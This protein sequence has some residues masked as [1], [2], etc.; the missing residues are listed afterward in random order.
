MSYK[1]PLLLTVALVL[2]SI[3]MVNAQTYADFTN[4]GPITI[5]NNSITYAPG[6]TALN[7]WDGE[8]AVDA[9]GVVS[10]SGTIRSFANRAPNSKT[11]NF[12]VLNISRATGIQST[13]ETN[14]YD[15]NNTSLII[16]STADFNATV[17]IGSGSGKKAILA[18]IKG[19]ISF[20]KAIY[21]NTYTNYSGT[22][23]TDQNNPITLYSTNYTVGTNYYTTI[24]GVIF[25]PSPQTG[26]LNA[27][28][29]NNA[30]TNWSSAE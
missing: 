9:N 16:T 30:Q 25:G 19:V 29:Q 10:G 21:T 27:Y 8:F 13:N 5:E 17:Q 24:N 4:S 26:Y 7:V 20:Q 23:W 15:S 22:D 1:K 11:T 12:T 14:N 28:G 3:S 18:Q 6:T 2:S